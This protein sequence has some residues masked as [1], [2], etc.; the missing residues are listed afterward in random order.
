[1]TPARPRRAA[2]HGFKRRFVFGAPDALDESLA[3]EL[4]V[5]FR[6][7]VEA[8]SEHLGRDLVALWGYD[9]DG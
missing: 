1:M 7:E 9:R 5:R 8:L 4:R 6:P 3:R 2:F